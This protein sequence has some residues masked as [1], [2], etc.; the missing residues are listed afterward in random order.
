MTSASSFS[1]NNP[2]SSSDDARTL[3]EKLLTLIQRMLDA[4]PADCKKIFGIGIGLPGFFDP[5]TGDSLS[6]DFLPFW[7]NIP[8]KKL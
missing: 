2:V 7:K 3:L 4:L 6:Y 1:Q 8:I 5:E